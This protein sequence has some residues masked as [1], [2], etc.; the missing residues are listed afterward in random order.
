MNN[1]LT[2]PKAQQVMLDLLQVFDIL[3]KKHNLIYWLDHGTLLGA[4]RH[5]GFIP[6][7][8]D[9][10]VTMPRE[11]YEI[12]LK[13]VKEELPESVFL[14]TKITDPRSPVHYAKLRDRNSTYIDAWEEGKDVDY[15][16]GIFIDIFP[17]NFISFSK[18]EGYRNILNI[19]KVF[20]N[21]YVKIDTIAKWF[22]DKLNKFHS[23]DNNFIVSGGESMHFITH[24]SKEI[25]FPLQSLDFEGMNVPV[26]HESHA[27]LVSIF[28]EDYMTLP[29]KEKQKV[30]SVTID[31]QKQCLYEKRMH[32]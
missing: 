23:V 31:T 4:V 2:I 32:G 27:Y 17:V 16:Q 9:L 10:D 22:I 20:S 12:F 13:V 5:K 28:G 7:D 25:V 30:H 1:N 15:H 14:Q 26:P 8:D 19:S 3:C 21:R 11:D 6:W 29:P 24:V 18:R